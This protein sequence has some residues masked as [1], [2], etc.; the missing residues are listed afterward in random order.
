MNN[1]T[2][3]NE[4]T[5]IRPRSRASAAIAICAVLLTVASNAQAQQQTP[6]H[7][8]A[9][10]WL[11]NPDRVQA[12]AIAAKSAAVG[13]PHAVKASPASSTGTFTIFD[14]PGAGTGLLQGTVGL[15]IN[16]SGTIAGYY[17]DA[18]Y[19]LHGVVRTKDG[20][21]TTFD[22]PGAVGGT[23]LAGMDGQGN[24][25]GYYC[26]ATGL[27][28]GFLRSAAGT[29]TT[30]DAPGAVAGTYVT[31]VGLEGVLA[32]YY[33][34][35][36]YIGRGFVRSTNGTIATFEVPGAAYGTY[37]LTAGIGGVAGAY[38][39]TTLAT[40]IFTAANGTA[41]NADPPGGVALSVDPSFGS[42][43][44]GIAINATGTIA[45]YYFETITGNPYGGNYRGFLRAS[46]GTFTTFDAGSETSCCLWTFPYGIN[47]A[48]AATGSYN[49][50]TGTNHGFVRA[51]DGTITVLDV[52]GAVTFS[53]YGYGG[54]ISYSI[55]DLGET[56]GFYVD[57][58]FAFHG[59]LY[60]P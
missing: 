7:A 31:S 13:Q 41:T 24:I 53:P 11:E 18:T 48:G 59:F 9:P 16:G 49:D 30:F 5:S 23:H 12:A 35:G 14:A 6:A 47:S 39:D 46:D 43:G 21:M 60:Q 32:G 8:P 15:A 1:A 36:Q 57:T 38:L 40:H 26:D 54:T 22:A 27:C 34:D 55:N 44:T 19:G 58:S 4:S 33:W 29:F 28:H 20:T 45:G 52:P 37:P 25:G 10:P 2:M 51:T 50:D 3:T 56:T 42:F 17:Y